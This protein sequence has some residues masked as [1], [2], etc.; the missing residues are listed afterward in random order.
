MDGTNRVAIINT[1]MDYPYGITLDYASKRVY[2]AVHNYY[3]DE[4]KIE[5]S[6]YY[7]NGRS[8]LVDAADG[9]IY[10]FAVT[11]YGNLIY[12]T[13]WGTLSVHGTHKTH[14]G[15]H[16]QGGTLVTEVFVRESGT[17]DGIEAVS[18]TRQQGKA[19]MCT[20]K[21]YMESCIIY[22]YIIYMY[23][24]FLRMQI[25]LWVNFC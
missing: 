8:V 22:S 25:F 12:W 3:N 9:V 19:A 1:N 17:L 14:N 15:T 4:F 11:I 21:L 7:G 18:P 2:W 10:P 23:I 5:F 24:H 20:T 16:F 6:D 13:D